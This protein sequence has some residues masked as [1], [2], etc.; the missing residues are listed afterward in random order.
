MNQTCSYCGFKFEREE[1]YF[2]SAIIIA[3][4]LY[5]FI[6]APIMLIMTALEIPFWKIGLLLGSVSLVMVPFIFRFA[7]TIWLHFDFSINPE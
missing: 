1:G 4:F 7:R 5:A 2:T 6:V 3:N